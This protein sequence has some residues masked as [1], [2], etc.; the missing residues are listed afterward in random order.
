MNCFGQTSEGVKWESE[1][2][3]LL[4]I[5]IDRNLRFDEYVLSQCNKAGKKL[6]ALVRICKFIVLLHGYV[7]IEV[8]IIA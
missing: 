3:K 7:V 5:L 4:G 6:G 1:K 8:M 2:V